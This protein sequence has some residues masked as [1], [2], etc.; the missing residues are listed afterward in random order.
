MARNVP[1][2]KSI[3]PSSHGSQGGFHG[4]QLTPSVDVRFVLPVT[5]NRP[6]PNKQELKRDGE[7]DCPNEA[8]HSGPAAVVQIVPNVYVTPDPSKGFVTIDVPLIPT[9]TYS[10]LTYAT[11]FTTM[12]SA[13]SGVG[14]EP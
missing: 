6:L 5:R 8:Y 14:S 11:S 2:P 9:R 13:P 3:L 1:F 12:K 4:L 10:R 7:V